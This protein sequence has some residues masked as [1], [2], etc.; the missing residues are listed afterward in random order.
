MRR[1][2]A[3]DR[4]SPSGK[5]EEGAV[6]GGEEV[7]EG[8]VARV[9]TCIVR[10]CMVVLM[11]PTATSPVGIDAKRTAPT[12]TRLE[13]EHSGGVTHEDKQR[14]RVLRTRG[15]GLSWPACSRSRCRP[16]Q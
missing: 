6:E 11:M 7:R 16:S 10:H 8:E 12:R 2:E 14:A 1:A 3:R 15:H 5:E 4:L 9:R 13:A